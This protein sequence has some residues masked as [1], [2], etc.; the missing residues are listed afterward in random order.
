MEAPYPYG[1]HEYYSWCARMSAKQLVD[2]LTEIAD[3][4][5]VELFDGDNFMPIQFTGD[6]GRPCIYSINRRGELRIDQGAEFSPE[7][8]EYVGIS[9]EDMANFWTAGQNALFSIIWGKA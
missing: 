8:S 1:T 6:E 5:H 2:E 7:T 3:A 4:H 9:I